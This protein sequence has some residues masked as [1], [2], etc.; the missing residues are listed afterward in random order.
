[1]SIRV[2][3][4]FNFS[5]IGCR[6]TTLDRYTTPL[7]GWVAEPEQ[8]L[9]PHVDPLEKAL[10]IPFREM[11]L[12][13]ERKPHPGPYTMETVFEYD[14]GGAAWMRSVGRQFRFIVKLIVGGFLMAALLA[15]V[16]TR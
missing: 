3:R 10:G 8:T 13:A 9:R 7:T 14:R 12:E 4:G 16:F 1:M 2:R 15:A 6:N 5:S 11:E